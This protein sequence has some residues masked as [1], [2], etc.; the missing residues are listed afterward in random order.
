MH[1]IT[2]LQP[3]R[4]P[5]LSMR[6]EHGNLDT[7]LAG[8]DVLAVLEFG[9]DPLKRR[10]PRHLPVALKPLSPNPPFEVWRAR[11]PIESGHLGQVQ[12]A[13]GLDLTMG[14][15]ALDLQACGGIGEASKLAYQQLE[16][17][18]A[19]SG[20]CWP[21]KIW[22]YIPGINRGQHDS[23]C[24]RQFCVGRAEALAEG[25]DELPQMPAATAIGVDQEQAA[26]QVYFIAGA[27]PGLHVE[28]PR[29]VNAWR[30]PRQYGPRS[31]LFSRGTIMELGDQRQFLISGTASV[32]GHETHH[33]DD[34]RLQ[35]EESWRNVSSLINEGH[36]LLNR[37][38]D[39]AEPGVL[40][41]VYVREPGQLETIA[42]TLAGTV[43]EQVPCVF[44]Q[45]DICRRDLLTEIDGVAILG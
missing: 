9:A 23:E 8:D 38:V 14:H 39:K 29:Q 30:Y 43:G 34:V 20:H 4:G 17:F 16:A 35:T 44:L 12:F 7:L 13:R 31:P 41:K 40:L 10:E 3:R 28:N 15:I 21:Y 37:P 18:L 45:G 2:T 42:A 32:V 25:F 26:L 5:W 11:G 19:R 1:A 6:Y 27:L 22:N 33:V 36:R 24:Y